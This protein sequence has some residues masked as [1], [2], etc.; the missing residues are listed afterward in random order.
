[1]YIL[2][3]DTPRGTIGTMPVLTFYSEDGVLPWMSTD[4]AEVLEK[5]N[6]IRK[7]RNVFDIVD[8][9]MTTVIDRKIPGGIDDK[10]EYIIGT[11]GIIGED[12]AT[13][14]DNTLQ[15]SKD[16]TTIKDDIIAG[17][18]ADIVGI[19]ERIDELEGDAPDY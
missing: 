14:K 16:I 2:L 11:L 6:E 8:S 10:L 3:R 9:V 13:V 7:T 17:I 12:M 18:K 15:N 1:M 4:E 19:K 5:F